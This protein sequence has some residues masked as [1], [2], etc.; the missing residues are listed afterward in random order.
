MIKSLLDVDQTSN[1]ISVR[2]YNKEIEEA[3]SRI[4]KGKS[5]QH[6]DALKELAKW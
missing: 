3:V 2:Q 1:R 6:K 5:V 4:D